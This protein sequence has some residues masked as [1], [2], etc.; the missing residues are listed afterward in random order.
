MDIR[1]LVAIYKEFTMLKKI[2]KK[3]L[4]LFNL[5]PHTVLWVVFVA[6]LTIDLV[7][8]NLVIKHIGLPDNP[9]PIDIIDGWLR[10][11]TVLNPG[12]VWGSFANKTSFLLVVSFVAVVFILWLFSTSCKKSWHIH[13]GCGM[14]LAGACGNIHDRLFNSGYVVD[15]IEVNLHFWPANPWP[16]FNIADSLLCVGVPILV[17]PMLVADISTAIKEKKNNCSKLKA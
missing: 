14:I 15:F 16:T 13:L 5:L 11:S 2:E 1:Y 4:A 17:I 12:A 7:S 9:K 10:F 8:K 3:D 6:G